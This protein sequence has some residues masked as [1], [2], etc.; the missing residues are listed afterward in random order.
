M[1]SRMIFHNPKN[2]RSNYEISKFD[3]RWDSFK[4]SE[5]A[6]NHKFRKKN[7]PPKKIFIA[8]ALKLK[9]AV[10]SQ[11]DH[12]RTKNY[13]IILIRMA[14]II[15]IFNLLFPNP[16]TLLMQKFSRILFKIFFSMYCSFLFLALF[17]QVNEYFSEKEN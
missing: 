3:F 17:L 13:H 12:N 15:I 5:Y 16:F 8:I 2:H 9:M 10:L 14:N 7:H 4:Q 1:R 6:L 11:I